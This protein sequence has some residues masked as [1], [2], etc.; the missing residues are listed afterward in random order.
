MTC[1][2]AEGVG[3]REEEGRLGV[4]RLEA[5]SEPGTCVEELIA[6]VREERCH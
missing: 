6:E 5:G 4:S 2:R 1:L 3:Q